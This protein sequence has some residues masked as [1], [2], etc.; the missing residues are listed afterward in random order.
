MAR[1]AVANVVDQLWERGYAPRKVGPDAWE[2]RCP[3]HRSSDYA[4]AITRNEFNHVVLECRNTENCHH[5]RI[6]RALGFTNEHVY[7][8][9]SDS[10]ISRLRGIDILPACFERSD[11]TAK[12]EVASSTAE[13]GVSLRESATSPT[14]PI[15]LPVVETVISRSDCAAEWEEAV[16]SPRICAETSPETD[17]MWESI[18]D[19]TLGASPSP[20]KSASEASGRPGALSFTDEQ[21]AEFHKDLMSMSSPSDEKRYADERATPIQILTSVAWEAKLFR[22]NDGRIFAQVPVGERLEIFGLE[23][24]AFRDWL[25]RG[26]LADVLEP[27]SSAVIRRAIGML[28]AEARFDAEIP[29]VFIRTG[30]DGVGEGSTYFIDLGDPGGRAIGISDRGW[31]AVDQPEVHFRRPEGFLPLPM[32]S[33]DGS[34]DLLRPYVNLT[35]ADFRL[36]FTW[37]TAVLRPVGPYPILVLNGEQ[38]AAKSTLVKVLRLLIDPHTC[39]ALNPPTST[40]NLMATAVNGWLLAYDNVSDIPRWL[41]DALCQLVFGGAISGRALFTNDDRS[42]I[43]AQRPVLLS[44]IGDFVH[45]PDLKDRCVFL[46]LPPIPS[47]R[48]RGEDEFWRAFHADRPRILGAVFDAIVGGLRELPSVHLDELPRM[49]DYAMWGEAVGRGLGWA[50]ESFLSTYTDNRK[51]ATMTDLVNSPLGNV[52]LQVVGTVR[53]L[54]GTPAQLHAKLTEIVGKKVAA[55]ADWP[56]TAENFGRELR[57]L[58]PQ[59]RL[60]GIGVNFERRP[61]GRIVTVQ[62]EHVRNPHASND[63]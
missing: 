6:I 27:P 36:M 7:A 4:L 17:E 11:T 14:H 47:T 52:L 24:A 19:S 45:W 56:K 38:A 9:T 28:E 55:S 5:T 1:D 31:L 54:A 49:A 13:H 12:S 26:Y 61:E 59:L 50:H 23:S 60:H 10:L 37:L 33:R 62:S 48:R 32:P 2:S 25:I 40:R 34:I 29:E 20:T 22:S 44:G 21:I 46:H 3:G 16:V 41:S 15:A 8:E 39:I 63:S 58:A 30:R 18:G 42:F 51:E 57:R 43:Y 35:E 53:E